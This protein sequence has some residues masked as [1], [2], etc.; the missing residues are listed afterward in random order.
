MRQLQA[1]LV[2]L[3][4]MTQA[5]VNTGPGIFG[6]RTEAAVR[7]FQRDHNLVADGIYGPRTRAALR[8][9][10]NDTRPAA[11]A[12]NLRRG[13]RGAEVRQLQAALVELDYMTQ[14]QVNTG[15]GIFGPR[16]EAALRRF[17]RDH[18]LAADGIYGPGTRAALREALNDRRPRRPERP[19]PSPDRPTPN[20]GPVS[21]NNLANVPGSENVSRAFKEKVIQI[22]RRLDMDPNFLMAVMS[23]ES[24]L[25]PRAVNSLSGATGLIQFLPSTARRLGTTTAELRNMSAERQL[26]FVERYLRPYAGRMD[27]IEDAY[28]AVFYPRALGRE[29]SYVLFRRGSREYAQN[30]GL[31]HNRDGTVTKGEAARRVREILERAR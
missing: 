2:K 29:N 3:G 12:V 31:D 17:Q 25:N 19:T 24:R 8:R 23:F 1:A 28:M 15:P 22:A 30:S 7:N 5:Q 6:P 16:T 27:T 26:D 11:P 4:Y 9:A 18:N 10:L 21:P 14:A 20:P 13:N